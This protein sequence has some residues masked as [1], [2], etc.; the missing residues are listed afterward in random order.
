MMRPYVAV[1]VAGLVPA[2]TVFGARLLAKYIQP[3]RSPSPAS[4]HDHAATA[5][6]G[7]PTR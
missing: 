3:A 5:P 1:L 2:A 7:R 4:A 6:P